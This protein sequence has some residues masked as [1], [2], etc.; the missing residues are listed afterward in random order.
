M[1]LA[2]RA[3]A[4]DYPAHRPSSSGRIV[5][6]SNCQRLAPPT[7]EGSRCR[8]MAPQLR[9][10]PAAARRLP[11]LRKT[12]TAARR[13]PLSTAV[14]RGAGGGASSLRPEHDD[15]GENQNISL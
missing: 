6:S 4:P 8:D 14:G 13:L 1:P 3:F 9:E 2:P 12:L 15:G 10:P 5:R 11:R 7:R